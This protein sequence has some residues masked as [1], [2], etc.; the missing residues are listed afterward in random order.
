MSQA[1]PDSG[2]ERLTR[3]VAAVSLVLSL[4]YLIWRWGWTLN[5]DALWFS[6]PLALAETYGLLAAACLTVAGWRLT[7]RHP[8]EPLSA[9]TVDVVVITTD[10][11]ISVLRKTALA[12]REIAYAHETYLLDEAHRDEVR[13]MAEKLG[14][15]YLRSAHPAQGRAS[16]LNYVLA[17]TRG[18]FLLQLDGDHVPLPHLLHRVLGFFENESVAVV[19]S[20]YD[21]VAD[22]QGA[23]VNVRQGRIWG[24][25]Q[26][27][28]R[29]LEPGR[30]R[31]GAALYLGSCAVLRRRAIEAVGGFPSTSVASELEVSLLLHASGLRSVYFD[32]SLAFGLTAPSARSFH[33]RHLRVGQAG[34]QIL[35]R[36]HP[37]RM[38]GLSAMQRVAYLDTLTSSIGGFQR[39]I[40]YLAPIVFFI[41]GVFPLDVG[42]T[43]FAAVFIPHI[44]LRMLS[45]RM[46]ARGHSSLGHAD[47][48]AMAS[49]FTRILS[50]AAYLRPGRP[51]F[52]R[53]A[54]GVSLRTAAPQLTLVLLTAM[55]LG[56]ALYA[57][58]RGLAFVVPGWGEAALWV[59]VALALWNAAIAAYV[60]HLTLGG[61]HRRT[62]HRF[63]DSLAVML[64]V[65]RYDGKLASTDIAVTEN[66][67]PTGLAL[68]CMYAIAEGAR[69]EMALPLSTGEVQVRGR[70]VR[71]T[72]AATGLGDVHLIGVEFDSLSTDA[73]DAIDLH[74]AHHVIPLERQRHREGGLTARGALRRLRELRIE[75]RVAV[76][77]PAHVS[78]G[79]PGGM[80]DLG[81]GLLEDVSPRGGRVLLDHPVDDGSL[82]TLQIPGST[83]STGGRVVFVHE[84]ETSLGVRFVAGFQTESADGTERPITT[85]WF[86]EIS[87][88]LGR[89]GSAAAAGSRVAGAA[90]VA[91]GA[92]VVARSRASGAAVAASARSTGTVVATRSR[93][94]TSVL[95]ARARAVGA[96]LPRSTRP[97]AVPA[98]RPSA[99]SPSATLAP[100]GPPRRSATQLVDEVAA[101]AKRYAA[102]TGRLMTGAI[103]GLA[104]PTGP[105]AA[106]GQM[107]VRATTA[108]AATQVAPSL[109]TSSEEESFASETSGDASA[110]AEESP[111]GSEWEIDGEFTFPGE[112]SVGGRFIVGPLGNV[113]V[114]IATVDAVILGRYAGTLRA[115]GRIYVSMLGVVSGRLEA[116]EVVVAEGATVTAEVLRTGA[117]GAGVSPSPDGAP[118]RG[119]E[120]S[121]DAAVPPAEVERDVEIFIPARPNT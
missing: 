9:A 76:G 13:E 53:W 106:D 44:A 38:A 97:Q 6:V 105:S 81:V 66:L 96:A 30:D 58:T 50:A 43:V 22:T 19:Q 112:L 25:Q 121:A 56:W 93:E 116:P 64:R 103:P 70:V 20:A 7:H 49:F 85:R 41:T 37:L 107:P 45:Y 110:A 1:G 94:A 60:I 73:R 92:A 5:T 15:G 63:A 86:G 14:V 26:L 83:I 34:M 35:R 71:H 18:Q 82:M 74:C 33:A 39:L 28:F 27:T 52:R 117:T 79:E 46:L 111:E 120:P 11:P 55:S 65:L 57:R 67:T 100:A 88:L 108:V 51:P 62:E 40:L 118:E 99:A 3:V 4:A 77:M 10:E 24:D 90:V 87:R 102:T 98:E 89:Y 101:V 48:E 32:E 69:V 16:T 113:S 17:R 54:D 115:T 114:D 29:V 104:K 91:S 8:P 95:A 42:A 36:H 12:A 119:V 47:R 78:T 72:I 68:R 59:T 80:R 84:L 109:T 2:R 21:V 61:R 31:V 75:R 23:D